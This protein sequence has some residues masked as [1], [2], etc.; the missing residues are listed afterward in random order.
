[1]PSALKARS[2]ALFYIATVEVEGFSDFEGFASRPP[3]N[4]HVVRPHVLPLP[5]G[6]D[7]WMLSSYQ[8]IGA[9]TITL[10]QALQLSVESQR[11]ARF[12]RC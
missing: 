6:F 2:P 12:V 4:F 11:G 1:M 3:F 8:E 7:R 9:S 10:L 5:R